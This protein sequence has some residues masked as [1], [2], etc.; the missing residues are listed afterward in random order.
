M[1]DLVQNLA[2][3]IPSNI[4]KDVER[5]LINGW[6]MEEVKMKAQA[7]QIAAFGHA[8]AARSL[9]GVGELKARI[10]ETAFHYWGTR[11]G[12][13]CW[14]DKQFLKEFLRDNPEVA[15]RNRIKRTVV[16]GAA[17]IFDASGKL[18]K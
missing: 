15:V 8:N 5:V 10:P 3:V 17:G 9:D 11:L 18:V 14:Q 12:Y 7:K 16:N 1:S 6:R 4:R 13:E 2:D